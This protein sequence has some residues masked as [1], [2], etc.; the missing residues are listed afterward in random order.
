MIS[1]IKIYLIV[2]SI[3]ATIIISNLSAAPACSAGKNVPVF[4]PWTG[5]FLSGNCSRERGEESCNYPVGGTTNGYY[6]ND[7]SYVKHHKEVVYGPML[8][9]P[10]PCSGTSHPA[11]T[12][13]F[14]DDN[15]TKDLS[16]SCIYYSP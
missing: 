4:G 15:W 13:S 12:I 5:S 6:C 16:G 2:L 9:I 1:R 10:S 14:E 11:G 3:I 7:S 8:T